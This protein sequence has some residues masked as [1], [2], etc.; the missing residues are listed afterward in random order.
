MN[1]LPATL[2]TP[3]ALTSMKSVIS[4]GESPSYVAEEPTNAIITS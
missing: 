4:S 1:F 2:K 3:F